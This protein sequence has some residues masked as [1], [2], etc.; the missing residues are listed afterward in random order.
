MLNSFPVVA[1]KFGQDCMLLLTDEVE[2][3]QKPAGVILGI[4]VLGERARIGAHASMQRKEPSN[5]ARV[6][7]PPD[8]GKDD[9]GSFVP[10][11]SNNGQVCGSK[12]KWVHLGQK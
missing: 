4:Q 9:G 12:E 3:A 8:R 10:C 6:W 5:P 7:P 1:H 11:A 2:T